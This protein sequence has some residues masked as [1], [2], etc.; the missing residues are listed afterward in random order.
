MNDSAEMSCN[1]LAAYLKA[2]CEMV[3]FNSF[4]YDEDHGNRYSMKGIHS[5]LTGTQLPLTA[6]KRC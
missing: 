1:V 2:Q 6:D 4:L 5:V 3:H